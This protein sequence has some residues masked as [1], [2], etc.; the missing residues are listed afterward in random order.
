MSVTSFQRIL[1]GYLLTVILAQI[2]FAAFPRIDLA[3]SHAFANGTDGFGWADGHLAVINLIIR[4]IGETVWIVLLCTCVFGLVTGR[5]RRDEVRAMAYPAL[6]VLLSS[7]GIVNLLLKAH[8]GRARPDRLAEFGGDAHFSAAWQVVSECGSNCSFTSGEV[9]MAS[10]LAI[11]AVVLLWPQLSSR[12]SRFLTIL[13]AAAYVV[14]VSV[15]RIGLGRHFLSDAVFSAL[16]SGGVSLILYP[17]LRIEDARCR[18]N[19]LALV[20]HV[21]RLLV[22]GRARWSKVRGRIS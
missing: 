14:G 17:V 10:G 20:E 16:F 15:L 11:P 8:V 4:R 9:A 13:L 7:G 2:T 3:V 5:L 19:A 21:R 22:Q 1:I 18:I 12:R 6:C